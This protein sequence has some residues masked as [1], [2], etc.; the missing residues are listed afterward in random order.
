MS[1]VEFRFTVDLNDK[2]A[3]SK[4]QRILK[5]FAEDEEVGT[6]EDMTPSHTTDQTSANELTIVPVTAAQNAALIRRFVNE[7]TSNQR[8]VLTWMQANPG[9]VSAHILKQVFPTFLKS[10]GQLPGVFR[11]ARFTK[12]LGGN[13]SDCPFVQVAWNR[14]KQCGIYRGITVEEAAAY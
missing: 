10:P 14:S 6:E 11:C 13:K 2:A 7:S 8:Q 1:Q 4:W 12:H 9:N 3:L 5:I